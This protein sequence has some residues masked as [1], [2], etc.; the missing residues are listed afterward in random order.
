MNR[1]LLVVLCICL[2][3]TTI[4]PLVS[5][6]NAA[7][8]D[9][10]GV[11]HVVSKKNDAG[12]IHSVSIDEQEIRVIGSVSEQV[13]LSGKEISLYELATYEDISAY[14]SKTPVLTFEGPLDSRD[15]N[16]SIDRFDE[17]RDRLYSKFLVVLKD[18]G[19]PE[20]NPL[21][22]G[23]PTYP[24][25]IQFEAKHQFPFPVTQSK[26]G[27][28]VQMVDDAEELGI[29]HA[30]INYALNDLMYT[31]NTDPEDTIVFEV[32]GEEFYFRKSHVESMD[33]QI[34]SLSDN[35]ILVNLILLMYGNMP[36]NSPAE[37]LI[38]PDAEL[39]QGTVF[40]FNTANAAGV[41]YFKAAMEFIMDRYT[42]EDEKY[43]RAVGYIVGNEVDAQWTWQNMGEKTVDEFMEHYARTVRMVYQTARKY[44]NHPRVYISL[45][46]SWTEPVEQDSLK[47]YKGREVIDTM[48]ALSK[49]HG[50]FPWHIAHHPYPENLFDPATWE[51]ESAVDSVDT[52]KVTFKNLHILAD[53][54]KRDTLKYNDTSR[55][56][57]LSEQGFHTPNY[58][59]KAQKLQAAAYAYAY[60]K[61]Q[62]LDEIDSFILHRHVDHQLE[63]GLN[64]GMWTFDPERPEP[65][66]P[67]VKKS[68]YHVFKKIDTDESLEVT[69]F[70]KEIIG[71]DTWEDIIPNFDAS[72]LAQR[73]QPVFVGTEWVKKSLGSH[74]MIANF[75]SDTSNWEAAENAQAV[76]LETQDAYEGTGALK[77]DFNALAKLWRGAVVTLDEPVDVSTTPYLNLALK[78]PEFEQMEVYEAKVKVYD[79]LEYAEG[80]IAL[81][82]RSGWNR[83]ALDL[84]DW[85]GVDSVDRIK[86]WVRAN[87]NHDWSG[88]FLIDDV[89]FS[90]RVVPQGGHTN[91]KIAATKGKGKL[92]PG[93][94]ME[95]VIAN[96]DTSPLRGNI[97]ILDSEDIRFSE[98]Y[99]H[100]N[101]IKP[102]ESKT[103]S[104]TVTSYR[105]S[106]E[107]V[108]FPFR[109]RARTI[110]VT[111]T[112]QIRLMPREPDDPN[113]ALLFDFED[114][115]QEWQAGENVD[116]I[117]RVEHFLNGPQSPYLGESALEAVSTSEVKATDWRTVSWI[118]NEP[119][120]LSNASEFF[121]YINSYGGLPNATYETRVTLYNGEETLSKTF[122]MKADNWNEI[123]VEIGDWAFKDHVTQVDISFRAVGND[124]GWTPR[125]QLD[126]V[127]YEKIVY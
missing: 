46:H 121:Y 66:A 17:E 64:L 25:D 96:Y 60:Y 67:G 71:I 90:K 79:G 11:H 50:D 35:G 39:G 68:I 127:G 20:S 15:F 94:K 115:V 40:A 124:M 123:N 122:P 36:K 86:V 107:E 21:I 9:D 44:Y 88:S 3:L 100:V 102:G 65:S 59:T 30:A 16:L 23:N 109:Y 125:F 19:V 43:G 101:G 38:H 117:E 22:V 75:N 113:V 31:E 106:S 62:F 87:T 105:T 12:V 114:D 37:Q 18:A 33:R 126:F 51:D 54:V 49:A 78:L 13:D 69:E 70:A 93:S 120:D 72:V 74:Q 27:L 1:S 89:F 24:S 77:V 41:K 14:K 6:V 92:Y 112:E 104:L 95:V 84:S 98:D 4:L 57:I 32:D 76:A 10:E 91:L 48:N 2:T 85:D 73:V 28:Q 58:S 108:S 116:T 7:E 45:T 8:A 111:P 5:S 83:V 63:G 82:P 29:S 81:D 110:E 34:K 80:L 103:F 119:V 56:I 42:R 55:R 52:P 61:T 26:K 47:Y 53:Y 99:V 118:P 97:E